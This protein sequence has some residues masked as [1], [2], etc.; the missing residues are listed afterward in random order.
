MFKGLESL[1]PVTQQGRLVTSWDDIVQQMG[2]ALTTDDK[3]VLVDWIISPDS[4]YQDALMHIA[5][6]LR[7]IQPITE[8]TILYRGIG[9]S[10]AQDLMGFAVPDGISGCKLADDICVGD[11]RTYINDRP[12]SFSRTLSIAQT[13]GPIVVSMTVETYEP[14]VMPPACLLDFSPELC[15]VMQRYKAP[16]EDCYCQDEVVLLTTGRE[17]YY[18]LECFGN[19]R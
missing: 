6:T 15:L 14:N 9:S 19:R 1:A 7:R 17:Q 16:L 2:R 12:L 3:A 13:Y 10:S 4:R 8:K 5:E 18:R 11:S